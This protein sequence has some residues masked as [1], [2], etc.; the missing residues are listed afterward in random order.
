LLTWG[1]IF[2]LGRKIYRRTIIILIW[3]REI[4]LL[5]K[6]R[7]LDGVGLN[8][9]LPTFKFKMKLA[10]LLGLTQHGFVNPVRSGRKQR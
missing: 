10:V 7:L 1:N 5:A 2:W 3:K 8:R 4:D 6:K 9:P